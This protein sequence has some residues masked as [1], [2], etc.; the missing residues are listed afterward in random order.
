MVRVLKNKIVFVVPKLIIMT[1]ETIGDSNPQPRFDVSFKI[2]R[3]KAQAVKKSATL[4]LYCLIAQ[5]PTST[6]WV[7][8]RFAMSRCKN[9][10]GGQTPMYLYGMSP[11]GICWHPYINTS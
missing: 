6:W 3:L 1:K 5:S 10:L 2:K 4:F 8:M 9:E 7:D 11:T